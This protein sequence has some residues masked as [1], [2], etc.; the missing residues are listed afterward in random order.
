M[1]NECNCTEFEYSLALPF[2]EIGVKLTF[3][4]PVATAEFS[5]Y[6]SKFGKLRNLNKNFKLGGGYKFKV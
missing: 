1:W 2:F 5:K 6:M 3:Y 4:S